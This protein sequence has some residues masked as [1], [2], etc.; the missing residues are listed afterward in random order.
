MHA[1]DIVFGAAPRSATGRRKAA[2]PGSSRAKSASASAKQ[3]QEGPLAVRKRRAPVPKPYTPAAVAGRQ[4]AAQQ[5]DT[6]LEPLTQV[7][8]Y[9]NI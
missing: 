4:H 5:L 9:V 2:A 7:I 8:G 1:V 6:A 3:P